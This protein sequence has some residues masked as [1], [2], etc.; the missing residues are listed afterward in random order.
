MS[1]SSLY[2]IQGRITISFRHKSPSSPELNLALCHGLK[3]PETDENRFPA[4]DEGVFDATS[5]IWQGD[6]IVVGEE[7]ELENILLDP[8]RNLQS[9]VS[10][11]RLE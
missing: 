5:L 10:L 11:N 6:S 4:I 3:K 7:T 1:P 8:P 9:K 2:S